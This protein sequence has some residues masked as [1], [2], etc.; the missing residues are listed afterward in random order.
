MHKTHLF[1]KD[2]MILWTPLHLFILIHF[3][4]AH[5]YI[6][7]TILYLKLPNNKLTFKLLVMSYFIFFYEILQVW[8]VAL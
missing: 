8:I 7:P 6:Y 4:Y 2:D 5:Y 3:Y 1:K